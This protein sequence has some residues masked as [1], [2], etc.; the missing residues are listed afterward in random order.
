MLERLPQIQQSS[1]HPTTT[2]PGLLC[3]RLGLATSASAARRYCPALSNL[4]N[5][6]VVGGLVAHALFNP[7]GYGHEGPGHL[8]LVCDGSGYVWRVLSGGDG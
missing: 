6:L 7:A 2:N 8:V 3:R 5:R 4:H 1:A